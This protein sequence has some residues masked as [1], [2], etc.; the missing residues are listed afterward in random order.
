MDDLYSKHIKS[1]KFYDYELEEL[2]EEYTI[3]LKELE[4]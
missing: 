4:K 2:I 1:R 3:K